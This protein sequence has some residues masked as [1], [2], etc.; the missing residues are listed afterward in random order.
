MQVLVQQVLEDSRMEV[1][2][3]NII[4]IL[5][6]RKFHVV[7]HHVVRLGDKIRCDLRQR[8]DSQFVPNESTWFAGFAPPHVM[9]G[10]QTH[11]DVWAT[12]CV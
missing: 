2:F 11:P 5:R 10:L 12:I 1:P 6:E 8:N 9:Q 4:S 7:V 3:I